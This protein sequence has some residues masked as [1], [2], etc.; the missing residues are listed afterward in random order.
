MRRY[1]RCHS[2]AAAASR[3]QGLMGCIGCRVFNGALWV[4]VPRDLKGLALRMQRPACISQA[5]WCVKLR[6]L[7]REYETRCRWRQLR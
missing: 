3:V 2:L 1:D 6:A 4:S 5:R 7:G